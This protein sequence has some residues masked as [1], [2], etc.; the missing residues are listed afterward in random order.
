MLET[1]AGTAQ[2][3][4]YYNQQ[5]RLSSPA[6]HRHPCMHRSKANKNYTI[7]MAVLPGV[8]LSTHFVSCVENKTPGQK[9]KKALLAKL[10][11]FDSTRFV[12]KAIN[13]AQHRSS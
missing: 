7:E 2:K 1:T 3:E 10:P 6:G 8:L 13:N 12:H 11:A 4:K 5:Y 9:K